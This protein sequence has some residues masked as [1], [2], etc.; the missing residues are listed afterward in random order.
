MS[1]FR[2]FKYCLDDEECCSIAHHLC[3]TLLQIYAD[4][5]SRIV[6]VQ[7]KDA[8]L[9]ATQ[10]IKAQVIVRML[11]LQCPPLDDQLP[12]YKTVFL[13]FL[14]G[15]VQQFF[16]SLM[17]SAKCWLPGGSCTDP[18][19]LSDS[20]HKESGLVATQLQEQDQDLDNDQ[21]SG[22]SQASNMGSS[23]MGQKRNTLDSDCMHL[24]RDS[25]LLWCTENQMGPNMTAIYYI[26]KHLETDSGATDTASLLR[27][28]VSAQTHI[29]K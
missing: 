1:Q 5:K 4:G 9:E 28:A 2:H 15:A 18:G 13:V 26:W 25:K 12:I 22:A 3:S 23:L 14:L 17:E 16:N 10:S 6:D 7:L 27:P 21:T 20:Y 11:Q 19:S 8:H 29:D 24:Q